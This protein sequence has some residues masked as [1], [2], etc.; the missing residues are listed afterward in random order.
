MD[1]RYLDLQIDIHTTKVERIEWHLNRHAQVIDRGDRAGLELRIKY[2]R[3]FI[4][5][6]KST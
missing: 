1:K 2:H 4:N 6:L 3:N 5:I